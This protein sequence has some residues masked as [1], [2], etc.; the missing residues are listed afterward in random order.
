MPLLLLFPII[1]IAI[2]IYS[3][4]NLLKN[5]NEYIKQY[6]FFITTPLVFTLVETSI[7]YHFHKLDNQVIIDNI[8]PFIFLIALNCACLFYKQL[9]FVGNEAS[10]ALKKSVIY[11]VLSVIGIV[12]VILLFR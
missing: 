9:S 4:I 8:F 3:L 11:D 5:K 1:V 2:Y 12:L 10:K 7:I 6:I